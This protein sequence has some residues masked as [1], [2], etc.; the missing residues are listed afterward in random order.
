[1]LPEQQDGEGSAVPL[2]RKDL[3]EASY[4]CLASAERDD[5]TEG[6]KER[7]NTRSTFETSKYNSCNIHLKAVETLETCF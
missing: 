7:C 5:A 1:V 6:G 4:G 3:V 2:I